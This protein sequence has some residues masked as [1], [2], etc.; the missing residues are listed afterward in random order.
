[1]DAPS[2]RGYNAAM[3]AELQF[4]RALAVC[5]IAT[6]VM[7]LL[8][9]EYKVFRPWFAF[10]GGFEYWAGQF[11]PFSFYRPFLAHVVEPHT[12][13]WAF[14]VG[15]GELA[16]GLS[17]VSGLFVRAASA[18]GFFEMLNL[19]AAT[20]M[21]PGPHAELWRYFGANLDHLCPALLFVIFFFGRAGETWGLDAWRAAR[22]GEQ[23]PG[24]GKAAGN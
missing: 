13:F 7:F 14:F 23:P 22:R 1:M 24:A 9:G 20:G 2:P 17:L 16:I 15:F 5:R 6:G 19:F 8:F 18:G 11:T 3:S 12:V 10:E 4:H 21:A